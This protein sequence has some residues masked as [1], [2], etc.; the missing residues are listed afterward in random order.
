MFNSGRFVVGSLATGPGGAHFAGWI[1]GLLMGPLCPTVGR[2]FVSCH[3][4][5][6]VTGYEAV[7]VATYPQNALGPEETGIGMPVK[8]TPT[9]SRQTTV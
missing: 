2:G 6:L 1:R 3:W 9:E 8:H 4:P 7:W 5:D